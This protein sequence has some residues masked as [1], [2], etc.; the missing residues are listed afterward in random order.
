MARFIITG[1]ITATFVPSSFDEANS[2]NRSV[3]NAEDGCKSTAT[4]VNYATFYMVTGVS[5]ESWAYYDFDCSSIPRNAIINSVSCKFRARNYTNTVAVQT[6]SYG[7][8]SIG[9]DKIG[10]SAAF[11]NDIYLLPTTDSGDYVFTRED[12]DNIKLYLHSQRGTNKGQAKSTSVCY[13]LYGADLTVN[14]STGYY[15]YDITVSSQTEYATVIQSVYTVS[16][17]AS[18]NVDVQFSDKDK[19]IIDD[20]SYDVSSAFTFVTGTTY[21]Y[22]LTNVQEDH[23]ILLTTNPIVR[24][25]LFFKQNGQWIQVRKIYKKQGNTWV[26]Q[27]LTWVL[28]NDIFN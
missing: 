15:E 18:T 20:N 10:T 2:H 9:T 6:N 28:N 23:L 21:R 17:G 16:A 25:Y 22:H 7:Q 19:V 8:L 26:E 5:Q 11:T 24:D 14:Y 3:T 12:L 4:T 27:D 1:T 13:K